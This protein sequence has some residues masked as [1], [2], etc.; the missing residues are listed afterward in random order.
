MKEEACPA[1]ALAFEQLIRVYYFSHKL[2]GAMCVSNFLSRWMNKLHL[3]TSWR[4]KK[5]NLISSRE[6]ENHQDQT[7][8]HPEYP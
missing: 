7:R 6:L 3:G 8:N 4:G 1:S 5:I 2:D